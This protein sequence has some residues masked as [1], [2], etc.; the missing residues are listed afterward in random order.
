MQYQTKHHESGSQ[1]SDFWFLCYSDLDI[2]I[3]NGKARRGRLAIK[4]RRGSLAVKHN[5]A[6]PAY[7]VGLL[8]AECVGNGDGD[9]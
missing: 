2:N 4:A 6:A 7:V 9:C 3:F 8:V 1:T 5:V